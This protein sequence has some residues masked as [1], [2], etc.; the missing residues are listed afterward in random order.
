MYLTGAVPP[1]IQ[2]HLNAGSV[3]FLTT[4]NIG[5]RRDP[6]WWWAADSGCFNRKTYKGDDYYVAW[7]AE[8]HTKERCLFATAPD[9]LGDG[10][11]T[12]ALS[13][14]WLPVLRSLGYP[15]ALVTQDGMTPDM[16][17][18]SDADWLFLGGT[19]SHKLGDEAKALIA[20]AH[21]HGKPVHCGRVN[22][23]KRFAAF[24]ALGCA[25][26]DGTF[27]AFGPDQLV[28]VLMSW[29]ERHKTQP[30]LFDWKD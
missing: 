29:I 25:S 1:A 20:A 9:V 23:G 2:P 27:V 5:N 11:A 17:P 28:P 7:L 4:P 30:A 12:I 21:A 22:S 14:T 8:Q 13:A 19:D 15:A 6:S 24:A 3:G 26:A 10:P 16:V 18:W